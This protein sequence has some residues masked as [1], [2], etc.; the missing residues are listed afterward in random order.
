MTIN[1]SL[2]NFF[3]ILYKQSCNLDRRSSPLKMLSKNCLKLSFEVQIVD[4]IS[5]LQNESAFVYDLAILCWL[6]KSTKSMEDGFNNLRWFDA[7]IF[8][9]LNLWWK[10]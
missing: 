10:N 9:L 3:S 8:M 1:V 6:F 4:S 7:L 5:G 2:L